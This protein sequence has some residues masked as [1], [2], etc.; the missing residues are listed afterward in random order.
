M[1]LWHIVLS[2]ARNFIY[3]LVDI[4]L[5]WWTYNIDM[6]CVVNSFHCQVQWSQLHYNILEELVSFSSKLLPNAH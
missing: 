4:M 5:S 3:L 6:N 2:L 1:V